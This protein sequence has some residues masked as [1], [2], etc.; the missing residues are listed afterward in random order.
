MFEI[1]LVVSYIAIWFLSSMVTWLLTPVLILA[2]TYL[3]AYIASFFVTKEGI[4]DS[5]F[6]VYSG[7]SYVLI[8]LFLLCLLGGNGKKTKS[9]KIDK[10][11]SKQNKK[12]ALDIAM[13][14]GP[15]FVIGVG[16]LLLKYGL[17]QIIA[18]FS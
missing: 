18:Y 13:V 14:A 16:C 15:G 1:I 10:R 5:A 6:G 11:Y 12:A 3:Y 7:F 9:G 17:D 2:Y 8:V 4:L